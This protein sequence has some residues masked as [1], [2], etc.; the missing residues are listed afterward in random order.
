MSTAQ[1]RWLATAVGTVGCAAVLA[2]TQLLVARAGWR[3]DLSPEQ[4]YVLSDHAQHILAALDRPVEI[5]GFLRSDDP[6]NRDIEGLLAR[7]QDAS[8][9]V[10]YRVVDVNRNP[11]LA[12][13]YGVDV[14]GAI[15][16]QSDGLRRDFSSPNEQTL[17]AAIIQV[18]RPARRRVYFSA[19]HGERR[20]GDRDRQL[21]Y[22]SANVALINELYEV[23]EVAL[24]GQ[25]PVPDDAAALVVAAPTRDLTPGAQRQIEAYLRRGGGVLVLLEPS[26]RPAGL[27]DLLQHYGIAVSD[28]AVLDE[29]ERMFAGDH[30]TMLVPGR[31]PEHPVSA[32]LGSTPLMSSVRALRTVPTDGTADGVDLL[33]TSSDSWRTP[34]L[35][36]LQNGTGTFVPG[37]DTRGPVPVGASV[38]IRNADGKAGRLLVYGDAD[39]ASNL[40][41]DYLANRDLLLNSVNWLAGEE[42]M[43]GT[44]PP[45]QAP[46]INQLFISARQGEAV[47]WLGTVVV[48]LVVLT[49]GLTG[50]A[51]RQRWG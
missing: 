46:G 5:I 36:V 34:D 25:T 35:T 15:V 49:L 9:Y 22:F 43:L 45:T 29:A 50:V 30:L 39:F 8:R 18:T 33:V 31:S 1:R 40:L 26:K 3:V 17:M 13:Q 19:G 41:L 16:V 14:Y 4:A 20:V 28:E 44:R 2:F 48:P 23:G 47:F 37:R 38:L 12:R 32:A 10:R 7:V 21:G 6:R 24:D 42:T 11:A 51:L 27:A